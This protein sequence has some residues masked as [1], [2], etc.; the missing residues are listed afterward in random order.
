[1][2]ILFHLHSALFVTS[3]QPRCFAIHM[4][5]CRFGRPRTCEEEETCVA[6]TL[7]KSTR[8]GTKG[9]LGFLMIGEE[10]D[11]LKLQGWNQVVSSNIMICTKL[12]PW[13]FCLSCQTVKGK[14]SSQNVIPYCVRNRT[15]HRGKE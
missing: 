5:E 13:N 15:F 9:R 14:I 2:I 11:F 10:L 4:V 3:E 7:R 12:S 1:M 6:S 8:Y